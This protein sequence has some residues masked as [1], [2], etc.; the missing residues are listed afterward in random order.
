MEIS[1]K[2]EQLCRENMQR[3]KPSPAIYAYLIGR[4]W[5]VCDKPKIQLPKG[6]GDCCKEYIY[7][8]MKDKVIVQ[9]FSYIRPDMYGV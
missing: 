7:D 8:R 5:E 3:R 6:I 2:L 9:Y 1:Q 4:M